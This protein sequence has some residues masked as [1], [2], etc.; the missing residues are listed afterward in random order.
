MLVSMLAARLGEPSLHCLQSAE[1][2]H[3]IDRGKLPTQSE[4]AKKAQELG[5]LRE[6]A[7]WLSSHGTRLPR[8]LHSPRGAVQRPYS[9]SRKRRNHLELSRSKRWRSKKDDDAA[10]RRIYPPL[11]AP[12]PA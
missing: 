6:N 5:R 1:L 8:S 10:S 9:P 12:R 11:L 2:Q 3:N 7:F 4:E